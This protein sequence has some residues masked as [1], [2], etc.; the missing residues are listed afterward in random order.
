MFTLHIAT[1]KLCR[2]SKS[3][4]RHTQNTP[5][6]PTRVYEIQSP[7]LFL[8]SSNAEAARNFPTKLRHV[9]LLQINPPANLRQPPP[10]LPLPPLRFPARISAVPPPAPAPS[11]LHVVIRAERLRTG[12]WKTTTTTKRLVLK[13]AAAHGCN[14][15]RRKEMRNGEIGTQTRECVNHGT[16]MP[17][18]NPRAR[19]VYEPS[20]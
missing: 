7:V 14:K 4:I 12:R 6:H 15:F 19:C 10:T 3:T 20:T 17:D 2:E 9:T 18:V 8:N 13:R 11:L 5:T 1:A 16:I